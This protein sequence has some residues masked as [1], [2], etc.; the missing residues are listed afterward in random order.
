MRKICTIFAFAMLAVLMVSCNSM[1][2]RAKRQ[3]WELI[4]ETAKNPESFS[5]SDEKIVYSNDSIC[6]IDFKGTGEN[7]F[8][9]TS[10]SDYEYVFLRSDK[11]KNEYS[12][13]L[14]ELDSKRKEASIG[15]IVK[16]FKEGNLLDYEKTIYDNC[17]KQG[18]SDEQSLGDIVQIFAYTAVMVKGHKVEIE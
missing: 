10:T 17:K 7:G 1:E 16:R 5:V 3:M 6:V 14:N 2:R 4:K 9:V 8:G 12:E 11:E 18:D 13:F 15:Q